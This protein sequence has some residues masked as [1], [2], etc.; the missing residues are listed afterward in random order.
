MQTQTRFES[1]D[2]TRP[3][4][5]PRSRLYSLEPIGI[6]TSLCESLSGYIARLADA[7]AVSVGDLVGRELSSLGSNPLVYPYSDQAN[8]DSHG[9]RA[10]SYAINGL[11]DVS[12]TWVE[13]LQT[14]TIRTDLR[15]LTLL[16]FEDL[17]WPH[18]IFR[19]RRAWCA[20]C[21]EDNRVGGRIVHEPLLW[22]FKAVTFCAH[23][24]HPLEEKC[25]HCSR[26]LKPFTV[27]SRPGYCSKCQQWL[28]HY[29]PSGERSTC[30]PHD[31]E[32]VLW[33]ARE[34]GQL[35]GA[36][37]S[38]NPSLREV[39][40]GNLR[41]CVDVVAEGNKSAFAE[42]AKMSTRTIEHL[43]NQ[44]GLP[45]IPT[46]LRISYNIKIPVMTLLQVERSSGLSY[47]QQARGIIQENRLPSARAGEN[48]RAA[49]ERAVLEQPPPRLSDVARRLNYIKLD[50][51]YRVDAKLCRQIAI[52]YQSSLRGRPPTPS[53]KRFCSESQMQRALEE[54]LAQER[55]PSP[56]QIALGLGFVDERVLRRKFP[57][58]CRAIQEKIAAQKAQGIAA[59]ERILAAALT[60]DPPPK[61]SEVCHRVRCCRPVVLRRRFASLCDQ[62]LERRRE[63]RVRHIETLSKELHRLSLMSPA[64]PLEQA[65]Q[66]VGLSRQRLVSLCPEESAALVLRYKESRRESTLRRTQELERSVREIVKRLYQEGKYPSFKRVKSL[67]GK[68]TRSWIAVT[69]AI[70]AAQ[71]DSNAAS[72]DP[73]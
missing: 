67:L 37:P 12:R 5:P 26:S 32:A 40:T 18:G 43:M 35:V 54:A 28:G 56:Y 8:S 38:V 46:L 55:P 17:F 63:F 64:L 51:L 44:K 70:R 47:W 14:A 72:S 10:R 2:C 42:A 39:F 52:N 68:S 62:L 69:S 65:C 50:R 66:R 27:H 21:Y 7:H 48:I 34:A 41:A 23:H 73:R 61:L 59:M 13:V 60:E 6:G 20:R 15:F 11:G 45:A 22:T 1:W 49:L 29:D 24:Q 9:F 58:F 19:R 57:H 25:P 30:T 36:A 33:Y 4:L 53:D 3:V 16:P 31:A 71:R